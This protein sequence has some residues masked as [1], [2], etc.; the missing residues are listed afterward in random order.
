MNAHNPLHKR[1]ATRTYIR[2]HSISFQVPIAKN[3][4]LKNITSISESHELAL[5][6][7]YTVK[8][9]LE[10]KCSP[11]PAVPGKTL[12]IIQNEQD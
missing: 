10:K 11:I 7:N 2:S 4:N 5:Y 1:F 6:S 9:R 3:F 8:K 12:H